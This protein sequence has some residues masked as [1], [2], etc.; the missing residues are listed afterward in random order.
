MLLSTASK[1]AYLDVA[2]WKQEQTD[3]KKVKNDM[4]QTYIGWVFLP[5]QFG[6]RDTQRYK[7]KKSARHC[8]Q[9][10]RHPSGGCWRT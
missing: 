3:R 10:S 1:G 9:Q 8:K 5:G 2:S 6:S 4:E 7:L